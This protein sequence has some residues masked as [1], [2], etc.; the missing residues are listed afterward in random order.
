[1]KN[2]HKLAG[3]LVAAVGLVL[4][5]GG[6]FT[7]Q[8]FFSVRPWFESGDPMRESLFR[9]ERMTMAEDGI[10]G[11]FQAVIFGSKSTNESK[12][13]RYFMPFGKTTLSVVEFKNNVLTPDGAPDRDIEA[14][15]FNIETRNSQ[16][17][18]DLDNAFHSL[19]SFCPR[20]TVVGLGLAWKQALWY[21]ND[22]DVPRAWFEMSFPIMRVT[23][24]MHL[25]E[26]VLQDGNGALPVTGLD[27][28]PRVGNMKQAFK[29]SN[30]KYG[31]I[32]GPRE[33]RGIGDIELKIGWNNVYCD[34]CHFNGFAGL[35]V[36]TGNRPQ[37]EYMFE[38]IVGNNHHVGILWGSNVG[39]DAWCCG[40]HTIRVEFDWCNRYLFR[41]HQVRSF[42]LQRGEWSRFLEVYATPEDAQAASL[43]A[44]PLATNA[45]TSGIN[46]FTKCVRVSPRFSFNMNYA[47]IYERCNW[48]VEG[49]WN[50]YARQSEKVEIDSFR[51]GVQVKD[52]GGNGAINLARTITNNFDGSAIAFTTLAN[53]IP[54]HLSDIDLESAAH[55][56]VLSYIVY[57]TAGYN[58]CDACYPTLAA[59][60]ASYEFASVNTNLERWALWGKLG[61]SF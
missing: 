36:P 33:Q 45:G 9:T 31:K 56:A 58:W 38:P 10:G 17:D 53:Y 27:N 44:E 48:Q 47:F 8:T 41:N 26:K 1:M 20:Q 51:S 4:A 39:F 11:A 3:L 24:D 18:D 21:C 54:L 49:G 2:I 57:L 55:P 43:I 60:G 37:G 32:N 59:V 23:N 14:R 5:E 30:W 13:A 15:N 52:I 25:D 50:F 19:I 6:D 7:S 42:D 29:Q 12:I 28:A 22:Y 40:E 46:V 35:V 16:L 61:I 34:A